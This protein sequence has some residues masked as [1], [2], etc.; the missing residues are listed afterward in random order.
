MLI[1]YRKV[2]RD[3]LNNYMEMNKRKYTRRYKL[4]QEIF[5]NKRNE[6]GYYTNNE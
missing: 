1:I 6:K 3:I 4:Q 5:K 2:Y